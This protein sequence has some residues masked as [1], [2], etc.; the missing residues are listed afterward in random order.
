M[1]QNEAAPSFLSGT[2]PASCCPVAGGDPGLAAPRHHLFSTNETLGR[3]CCP[4]LR[5]RVWLEMKD[6][7]ALDPGPPERHQEA[8]GARL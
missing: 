1:P 7:R 5:T 3:L 2:P 4:E 8:H 6:D